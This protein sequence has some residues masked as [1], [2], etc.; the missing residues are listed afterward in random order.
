M[1][2]DP[3]ARGFTNLK[4]VMYSEGDGIIPNAIYD[5]PRDPNDPSAR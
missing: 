1:Q 5:P 4:L 3:A 2:L